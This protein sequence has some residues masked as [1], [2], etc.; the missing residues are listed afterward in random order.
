MKNC[1]AAN[2]ARGIDR[3]VELELRP[4]PSVKF[5]LP[6]E[7]KPKPDSFTGDVTFFGAPRSGSYQVIVS[8]EALIDVLE[9]GTRL[10]AIDQ[11]SGK[12]CPGIGEAVRFDLAPGDLVLVEVIGALTRTIKVAFAESR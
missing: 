10:K 12:D 9:N 1:R 4:T 7:K 8:K 5:F 6:P 2:P 11:V 3:A